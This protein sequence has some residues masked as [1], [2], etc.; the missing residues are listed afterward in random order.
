[1]NEHKGSAIAFKVMGIVSIA[2][3]GIV[4][5]FFGSQQTRYLEY[6]RANERFPDL[7]PL[8][9]MP[10]KYDIGTGV[11]IFVFAAFVGLLLFGIGCIIHAQSDL[12]A[13]TKSMYTR[14]FSQ[15]A[16]HSITTIQQSPQGQAVQQ[17]YSTEKQNV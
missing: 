9:E 11:I 13:I 12:L 8:S 2:I 3:G 10:M 14:Q 6:L 5:T 15:A 7:Y 16:R 1:M 17:P 4:G